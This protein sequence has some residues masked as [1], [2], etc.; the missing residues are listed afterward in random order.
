MEKR[1]GWWGAV[2]CVA[3][4][5]FG[6]CGEDDAGTG[7]ARATSSSRGGS[8]GATTG[9]DPGRGGA[10]G[11]T[12]ASSGTAGA[13]GEGTGRCAYQR[14]WAR[15]VRGGLDGKVISVTTLD[16]TGP[17]SLTEALE[18]EGPRVIVFEVG[19]VIDLGTEAMR[20]REPYV[21]IAGQTAPSPGITLI[22]GTLRVGTHD[23]VVQHLRVRPGVAGQSTG[24]EPDGIAL[25]QAHD[26]IIDHCSVTWAVDENLTASGPRFDGDDV[27]AWRENTSHRVTFS[28]N[29]VAEALR[30]A[31]H[32]KGDHSM[33]SLI[34]DNVTEILLWGNLYASNVARNP[35]FKG[36]A[37]GAVVNNFIANPRLRAVRYAL[38][39]SEWD[40][41]PYVTGHLSIVGNVFHHGRDTNG[42]AALLSVGGDGPLDVFLDDNVAEDTDGA[43][44]PLLAGN[45]NLW[46]ETTTAPSWP[47]EV[48]ASPSSGVLAAIQA[49]VGA[50]PWD[51]DAIDT[52]IVQEALG[53]TSN[54]IDHEDE[55]GGYPQHMATSA[56]FV[57]AD[58][59]G[60]FEPAP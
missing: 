24:W 32:S 34:H 3:L 50:R 42:N 38:P 43:P 9:G 47:P 20:I 26:V 29:L 54:H 21:T 56:P 1:A 14:G 49:D 36:G 52:R 55:V 31:T 44:A 10:G 19:G 40:P 48:T 4:S 12:G 46:T 2:A 33:G 59:D 37:R 13:G 27:Q 35:L 22:R 16:P 45:A 7:G 30:N 11:T 15:D 18:T 39:S 17:G 60:C 6:G 51:R 25:F 58:W 53:G 23:V 57:A 41:R 5:L 28:R 8:D